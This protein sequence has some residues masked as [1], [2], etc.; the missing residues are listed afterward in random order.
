[1]G[2]APQEQRE[3]FQ[4]FVRGTAA[5]HAGIKGT[6]IGLSMVRQIIEGMGGQIRLTSAAGLGS[7]FTIVLPLAK[8]PE[9]SV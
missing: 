1:M 7:T 6:G 2:I 5:K 3:I 4:K 8:R 9:K